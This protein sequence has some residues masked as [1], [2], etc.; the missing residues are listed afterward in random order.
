LERSQIKLRERLS[1]LEQDWL[2][3]CLVSR[4]GVQRAI[5]SEEDPCRLN[6]EYDADRMCGPDLRDIFWICG[7]HAESIRTES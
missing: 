4:H 2:I 5:F 3:G 7:I 6:L 1:R